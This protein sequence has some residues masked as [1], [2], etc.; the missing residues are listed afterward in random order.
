LTTGRRREDAAEDATEV[1]DVPLSTEEDDNEFLVA[2]NAVILRGVQRWSGGG[3]NQ[4]GW[5]FPA[6]M[7]SRMTASVLPEV[8]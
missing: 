8:P 1:E 5:E 3:K 7:F 2:P 4:S 6:W